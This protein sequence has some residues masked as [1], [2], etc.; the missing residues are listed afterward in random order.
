L[1]KS[2]YAP[3]TA[4]AGITQEPA[5]R[6]GDTRMGGFGGAE[7]L[8]D[9]V[10]AQGFCALVDATHPFAV[11]ISSYAKI[12]AE[13]TS[14]PLIRLERPAW[15][16][17]PGDQWITVANS[18]AAVGAIPAR[19]RVLLTIGRKEVSPYFARPDIT[20]IARMIEPVDIEVTDNW[21]VLLARPP[22]SL[23][24]EL[25]L[26]SDNSITHLVTKNSGG[27]ETEPKLRAARL[28]GL[29]V[30]MIERPHK[31][32]VPTAPGTRQAL[33]LLRQVVSA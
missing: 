30:I 19:A 11:R 33:E 6:A 24:G 31:P 29:A 15:M 26:L 10:A 21:R 4:L 5:G 23:E 27:T 7:G 28:K 14:L 1:I 18:L 8:V 2:G 9:Y 13:R 17:Q 25:R 32:E 12:A 16:P 3:V 20:G 22:Y